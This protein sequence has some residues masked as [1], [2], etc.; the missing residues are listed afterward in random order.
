MTAH[1]PLLNRNTIGLPTSTSASLTAFATAIRKVCCKSL[2]SIIDPA[3]Q[4]S[5][6]LYNIVLILYCIISAKISF[7]ANLSPSWANLISSLYCSAFNSLFIKTSPHYLK[8]LYV[9]SYFNY[10]LEVRPGG[11]SH[12]HQIFLLVSLLLCLFLCS[13][14]SS[15]CISMSFL[16]FRTSLHLELVLYLNSPLCSTI[17]TVNYD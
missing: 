14:C 17:T 3:V 5:L 8:I 16:A 7:I 4:A 12:L 15:H 1:L 9:S 10:V 2:K 13:L 11:G 6:Y